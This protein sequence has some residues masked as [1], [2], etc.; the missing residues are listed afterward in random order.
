[1]LQDFSILIIEQNVALVF[2]LSFGVK[3]SDLIL[4]TIVFRLCNSLPVESPICLY[5]LVQGYC[6]GDLSLIETYLGCVIKVSHVA[7][8]LVM[9]L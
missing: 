9:A 7:L 3:Y 5:R 2:L 4:L 1:M 8:Y 6:S